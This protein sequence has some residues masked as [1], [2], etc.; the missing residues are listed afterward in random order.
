LA[1]KGLLLRNYSQNIDGLEFLANI[2]DE[3]LVEC[4]G[5]FRTASCT[6]CH[7]SADATAVRDTI[8][9]EGKAPVCERCGGYVKPDIVFFGEGLPDQFHILLQ[10]DR[11]T[12][13]LVLVLGTSLQVAPVSMIPDLVSKNCKRALLNRELVGSFKFT[14]RKQKQ[15]NKR[16][17]FVQGDC[18]DSIRKLAELLGWNADLERMHQNT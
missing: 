3:R 13:D 16:D 1:E 12:A 8:V 10:S 5:H 2:P 14:C 15:L 18:D 11:V 6:R 17:V 7:K 4:H 9:N